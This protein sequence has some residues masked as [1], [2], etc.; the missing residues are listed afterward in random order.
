MQANS[1][2][3][4]QLD[5]LLVPP[6]AIDVEAQVLGSLLLDPNAI[7]RIE[8]LEPEAFYSGSHR[9]IYQA[10]L[11]QH[12]SGEPIDMVGVCQKLHD[13]GLLEKVGGQHYIGDLV[14]RI[15]SAVHIDYHAKIL[16]EKLIRRRLIQYSNSLIESAYSNKP[17]SQVKSDAEAGILELTAIESQRGVQ[18]LG[19]VLNEDF[20]RLQEIASGAQPAPGIKS[21]FYDLDALTN[22]YKRHQLVIVAGRPSMGK[23]SW[24]LANV[25][26]V[27]EQGLPAVV[28]SMEMGKEETA[29]VIWGA[30]ASI[31]AGR[32]E[33]GKLADAELT[34]LA[35]SLCRLSNL[36]VFIDQSHVFTVPHIVS[37]CR[38]IRAQTGQLGLVMIDY[39]GLMLTGEGANE[40]AEVGK[41]TRALKLAARELDC[42]IMLL[43]QLNRN[44][45][46]KNEKRP[47]L[48]DLRSSGSIE[49]D[50][51]IVLMLYRDEYYNPETPDRGIAEVLVRKNRSGATGAVKLLFEPQFRRFKNLSRG[52]GSA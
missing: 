41:I 9:Q 51:D 30:D 20:A 26:N 48:S 5:D 50:A 28:F 33:A 44:V 34:Q 39:L 37:T 32:L 14:Y 35:S 40:T 17:L 10:M 31:D 18:M 29:Q 1:R 4:F 11:E 23:S 24:A 3:D 16:N 42:P 36:P 52:R 6:N 13:R 19:E 43:S 22:G 12:N 45:E 2:E 38:R 21:G 47:M 46:G 7:Y 49:Q 15:P 25:R 27:A 8:G